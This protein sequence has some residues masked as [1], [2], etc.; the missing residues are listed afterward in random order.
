MRKWITV[1][2][3]LIG[4]CATAQSQKAEVAF[5]IPEKDLIPEGI[6]Y[7]A[8]TETFYVGSINKKKIVAIDKKGKAKDFISSGQEGIGNVLGMKA[9]NGILWAC[10]NS[11]ENEEQHVHQVHQYD[12]QSGKLIRSYAIPSD[13]KKHLLNDLVVTSKG[14]V[15]ISD[16]DGS[17][18]F[19]IDPAKQTIEKFLEAGELI[20]ANGITT[21]PDG[22]KLIV[23]TGR[24][25]MQVDFAT[26]KISQL[27]FR[28][29]YLVGIDGLCEYKNSLIGIQNVTFPTSIN[30]YYL[31][32][33]A[34]S[35][36]RADVL[37]M[38]DPLFHVPTTG[39]IV[40]DWFYFITNS[41]LDLWDDPTNKISESE[42]LKDV[43][44][45]KI[46]LN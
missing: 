12:L 2:L 5:I 30:R 10:N 24:G 14:D 29:Y 9:V 8:R 33:E 43:V 25:L 13:D 22:N 46:R 26:K 41:H 32:N 3:L 23:S 36:D 11:P 15:F 6:A 39:V 44:I 21:S 38:E 18:I 35:I 40:N 28:E 1:P 31:N 45:A 16:A 27:G 42:K 4:F 7:D 34:T 17:S 37:I 19:K 20:Y